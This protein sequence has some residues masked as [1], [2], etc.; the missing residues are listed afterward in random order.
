MEIYARNSTNQSS[1]RSPTM[2][3]DVRGL[4]VMVVGGMHEIY[5][6][7]WELVWLRS[8][9]NAWTKQNKNTSLNLMH[10]HLLCAHRVDTHFCVSSTK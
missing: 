8:H 6:K 3:E 1:D 2:Y 4:L 10:G 7:I 5:A 9:F